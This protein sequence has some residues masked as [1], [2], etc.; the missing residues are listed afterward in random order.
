LDTTFIKEYPVHHVAG[1]GSAEEGDMGTIR[2]F[3]LSLKT[4]SRIE[5]N[6]NVEIGD[7]ENVPVYTE[8]VKSKE[9]GLW[10]ESRR[11][12]DER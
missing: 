8:F 1:V 11:K 3:F 10:L 6:L 2:F 9:Y 4:L 12:F 7:L 5:E